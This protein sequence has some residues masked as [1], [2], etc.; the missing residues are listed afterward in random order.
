MEGDEGEWENVR[1]Y[2]TE[3]MKEH[4]RGLERKKTRWNMKEGRKTKCYGS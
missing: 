2:K 3:K 1:W 4:E